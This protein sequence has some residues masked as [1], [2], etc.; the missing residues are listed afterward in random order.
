[1]RVE[2]SNSEAIELQFEAELP[3]GISYL[4]F[5]FNM[6]AT[7]KLSSFNLKPSF[8]LGYPIYLVAQLLDSSTM[9]FTKSI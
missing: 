8:L 5:G 6:E 4:L 7:R 3:I 9:L 1:V 2:A